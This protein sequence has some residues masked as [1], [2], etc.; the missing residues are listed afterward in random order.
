M[1]VQPTADMT[2]VV[3]VATIKAA[4]LVRIDPSNQLLFTSLASLL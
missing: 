3:I 2:E 4:S 1:I